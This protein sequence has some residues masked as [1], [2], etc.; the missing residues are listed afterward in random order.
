MG[1]LVLPMLDNTVAAAIAERA[2]IVLPGTIYNYGPDTFPVL[3]EDSPQ[4]PTTRKGLIRVE[5]NGAC[6]P[7]L[8]TDVASSSSAR[9][10][11][12]ART[13][14]TVGSS[15]GLV[16]PGRPVTAI[17]LPGAPGVAHQWSYVPDVARAMVALLEHRDRLEPFENF[18]MAGHWDVDGTQMADSIARAVVRHGGDAPKRKAFPWW[19]VALASPI[20][21]TFREMREMRYLWREPVRMS[22]ARLVEVLGYEAPHATRRSGHDHIGRTGLLR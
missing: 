2:T 3:S 15:Q 6:G 9:A 19:L 12:S 10:T 14:A 21:V 11:S 8:S 1:E 5:W 7:Q 13:S 18:H 4:R 16:K 20:V 17:Q 22:N